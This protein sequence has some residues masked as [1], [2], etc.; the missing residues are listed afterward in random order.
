[1]S[2]TKLKKFVMSYAYDIP[3]YADFI[4]EAKDADDAMARATAAL[5]LGKFDTVEGD[6]CYDNIWAKRVFL[7]RPATKRDDYQPNMKELCR[8][9]N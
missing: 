2:K 7:Q 5:A 1:M 6:V 3:H 8:K 9:Q 4:I